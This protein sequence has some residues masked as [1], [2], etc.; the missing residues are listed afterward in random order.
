MGRN[1]KLH[2]SYGVVCDHVEDVEEL[3]RAY[4]A[5]PLTLSDTCWTRRAFVSFPANDTMSDGSAE[6]CWFNDL[7]AQLCDA[8][9]EALPGLPGSAACADLTSCAS[10][11]D[12]GGV[13]CRCVTVT[14][15]DPVELSSAKPSRFGY[16]SIRRGDGLAKC[17]LRHGRIFASTGQAQ[18]MTFQN[19]AW[20]RT[21]LMS[22]CTDDAVRLLATE[23]HGF[24]D[25]AAEFGDALAKGPLGCQ[26]V[27]SGTRSA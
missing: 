6:P 13:G 1:T 5:K 27:V 20:P 16:L 11:R 22:P 14:T 24:D 9:T 23:P 10:P 2:C 7:A 26:G 12:G 18:A 25:P 8:I 21:S 17:S 3:A 15:G 19:V 4:P